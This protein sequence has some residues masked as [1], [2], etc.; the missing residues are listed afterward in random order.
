[1]QLPLLQL[2]SNI[3]EVWKVLTAQP[4]SVRWSDTS[5]TNKSAAVLWN[6]P[7]GN[8][9]FVMGKYYVILRWHHCEWGLSATKPLS[10]PFGAI[11]ELSCSLYPLQVI[12][13][14]TLLTSYLESPHF[15]SAFFL[16]ETQPIPLTK[17]ACFTC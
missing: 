9:S 2:K 12:D 15:N 7:R 6:R 14:F 5:R 3:C 13:D 8:Q 10:L 17:P 1:M 11:L 4:L 16:Q